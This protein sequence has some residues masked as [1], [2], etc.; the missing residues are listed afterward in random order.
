MRSLT[1]RFVDRLISWRLLLLVLGIAAAA[2]ALVPAGRLQFD[3]SIEN[4]FAADDPLLKPYRKLKR[5]FGGNE[6]VLAVYTDDELLNPDGRGI[7]RLAGVNGKLK[8]VPGVHDVFSLDQ[9]VGEAI[10]DRRSPVA[11][12]L[13]KLL[14]GFTHDREGTTAALA[15]M[16]LPESET[17]VPRRQV[18][19]QIRRIMDELP[20]G[21][22]AGEPV[23]VTEGFR[24]VEQD[25]VLLGWV[26]TVL[27]AVTI[28]LC[29]RSLRWVIVPI[30]VVQLA[31]LL[32][33]ATLVWSGLELSMVS[34]ALTA[35]VTVVGIATVVHITVRF[36]EARLEGLPPRAA[37]ARAGRL[38]AAPI[39]W[40][41]A[42]TAAGFAALMVAEVGP[43]QD[44]GLM[45]A[46]GTLL[47]MVC[48][49]LLVPGLALLG[50]VDTDPK[51]AWGEL[52]LAGQLKRLVEAVQR[53]PRLVGTVTLVVAAAATLGASRLE[54]ESDF[55]RNFRAS[56]PIVRSYD[57]VET[58]L[59]GAGV[60]DV[61]LPAPEP[62]QISVEYFQR[63][64]RLE[65]RLR[66]EVLVSHADGPPTPGLSKVLSLADVAMASSRID[67]GRSRLPVRMR[68]TLLRT[69]VRRMH[70][71]IP[72]FVEALHGEDPREPGRYYLRIMLRARERQPSAEKRSI[73]QQVRRISREE[74]PPTEGASGAEVTGFF[75][76]L[77]RLIDSVMR[78]QW[79]T[80][81]V[82]TA[83]IGLM[84]L[85]ALRNVLVALAALVPN[86]LPIL[87][88]TGVMGWLGLK[89][90]MGAA[91]IAAVSMGLSI[92]SSIHYI[93]AFRA[94][95]AEGKSLGDALAAVHGSVGRAV[96][97]STLA[98]IVGFSALCTSQFVPTVY[99]GALVSLS[100]LGGL[101]GNLAVLPLLLRLVAKQGKDV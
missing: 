77:T 79:I 23:M 44:F 70:S 55:T 14:E 22:I 25:G 90:N 57:F 53:R 72:A 24:L 12:R 8:A 34:S 26:S 20:S 65:D 2:T 84:M 3:R 51:Q 27:L 60:W 97:L 91:M 29:F 42:T 4:M 80:F 54:I 76:L 35:V 93:T 81:G 39:F 100:M 21:M 87:V 28:V 71:R 47:V 32:T 101:L 82:A 45:M 15:C 86:A 59:E 48:V 66:K 83:A 9:P 41:C 37:L 40:A 99:F 50:R 52:L 85:A 49:T 64:R 88:V 58:K 43:V 96:V 33:R 68:D 31:I 78:D 18:V 89:V 7:R 94:A 67:L 46:I 16:L 30:A 1:Q 56:S 69:V 75:V 38:L 73:I 61:V 92:D 98:L 62:D 11:G 10:V 17:D 13:R 6:I 19:D 95:R 36:R 74:F 5:T 63:V